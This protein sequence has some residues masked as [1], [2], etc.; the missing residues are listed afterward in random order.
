MQ[1]QK[2]REKYE[3]EINTLHQELAKEKMEKHVQTE[4][5]QK[6]N[7]KYKFLLQE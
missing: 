5:Y 2:E 3:R 1:L 6:K 4:A 7:L